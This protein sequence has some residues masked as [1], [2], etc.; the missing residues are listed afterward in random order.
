M[1]LGV[2]VKMQEQALLSREERN[3]VVAGRSRRGR[4]AA[5]T[6]AASLNRTVSLLMLFQPLRSYVVVWTATTAE[7]T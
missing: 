2:A 7:R 5:V 4:A 1:G 3:A 6:V